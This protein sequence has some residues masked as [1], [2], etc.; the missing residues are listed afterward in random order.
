M[1]SIKCDKKYHMIEI[2]LLLLIII[3]NGVPVLLGNLLQQRLDTPLDFNH[4]FIDG[5]PLFGAAKTLRGVAAAICHR[6]AAPW[7]WINYQ[8]HYYRCW[9]VI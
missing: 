1:Y 3:A 8:N 5:R 6:V 7:G 4:R 2:K 9:P